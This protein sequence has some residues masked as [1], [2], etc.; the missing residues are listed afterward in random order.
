LP[1]IKKITIKI[2]TYL[3]PFVGGGACSHALQGTKIL[4]GSFLVTQDL[5]KSGDLC[6]A[7]DKKGVKFL[8][9]NAN[10]PLIQKLY[11][12]DFK[13]EVVFASRA[14]DSVGSKR[15]KVQEVLISNFR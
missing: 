2:K 9:S 6:L 8:L 7:L 11:A 15:G 12:K 10:V 4:E 13:L 14:I 3:E 1:E 5:A